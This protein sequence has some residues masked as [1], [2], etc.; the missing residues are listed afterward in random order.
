ME[1]RDYRD[2]VN[3]YI[4]GKMNP[5]EA[6]SFEK[7]DYFMRSVMLTG[8]SSKFFKK[9]SKNIKNDPEFLKQLIDIYKDDHEFIA[10]IVE[11][12]SNNNPKKNKSITEL[13]MLLDNIYEE[14]EDEVLHPAFDY[15]EDFFI[16]A[17]K[18]I[19]KE[20]EQIE[21]ENERMEAGCGFDAIE[22]FYYDSEIV[23]NWFAK[24]YTNEILLHQP[25]AEFD[26]IIHYFY[27]NK[28]QIEK[29][30]DRKALFDVMAYFDE[31]LASYLYLHP[32]ILDPYMPMLR[33][34]LDE[35]DDYL[36]NLN[37]YK[38]EQIHQEMNRYL[39]ENHLPKDYKR[40][41][42]GIIDLTEKRETIV[43]YLD[44][45]SKDYERINVSKL[46][47]PE[48][49]FVYYMTNFIDDVFFIDNEWD[50]MEDTSGYGEAP[51]EDSKVLKVDFVN[52]RKIKE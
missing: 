7:N 37:T 23:I 36:E 21:D 9:C 6:T 32:R 29:L 41:F 46:S 3:L 1:L 12:F 48:L 20:I 14:T 22:H 27:D 45:D 28:N 49:R 38:I 47:V 31:N 4:S 50:Y 40:L 35:W 18:K 51:V 10:S 16:N 39:K 15:S 30:G 33:N 26:E 42:R 19:D 52:K 17:K 8:K 25:S 43:K 2:N 5:E 34:V 44:D 11:E 24:R 13:N